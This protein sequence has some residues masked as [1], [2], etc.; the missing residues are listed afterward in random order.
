MAYRKI[1]DEEMGLVPGKE[2]EYKPGYPNTGSGYTPGQEVR[3]GRFD[4]K[5]WAARKDE[6]SA[7]RRALFNDRRAEGRRT[8]PS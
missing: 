2:P 6:W 5:D 3:Y 8:A 1:S 4:V 7:R